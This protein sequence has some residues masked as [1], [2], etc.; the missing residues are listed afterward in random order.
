MIF[1]TH[2]GQEAVYLERRVAVMSARPGRIKAIIETNFDRS[3]PHLFKSKPFVEKVDEI[4]DLVAGLP[5]KQRAAI[6]LRYACD[7]R[8]GEMATALECSEEA[9]R[10]SVHE[11]LK[12]LRTSASSLRES[13]PSLEEAA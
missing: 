5:P 12:K 9:A 11:G 13:A 1:V 7:L 8:Y 4:W 6:T 3:D 2:D 10:R